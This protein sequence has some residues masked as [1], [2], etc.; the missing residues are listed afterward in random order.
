M[1]WEK[2][3]KTSSL[4]HWTCVSSNI[5]CSTCNFASLVGKK[6]VGGEERL[7]GDDLVSGLVIVD[8][9]DVGLAAGLELSM[10]AS[11]V[12]TCGPFPVSAPRR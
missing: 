4:V 5:C 7:M 10:M 2:A 1:I 12:S 9:I 6:T 11:S 3:R 8:A